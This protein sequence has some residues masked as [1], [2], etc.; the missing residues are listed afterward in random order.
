M[1]IKNET[2]FPIIA[3]CSF[4]SFGEGEQRLVPPNESRQVLGPPV[5][6]I[7]GRI[8]YSVMTGA[9]ICHDNPDNYDSFHIS[10]GYPLHINKGDICM[11][12]LHHS[13]MENNATRSHLCDGDQK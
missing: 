6:K 4:S 12:V 1:Q 2:S 11:A 8:C 7:E 5:S 9:I 3:V 13:D 10:K